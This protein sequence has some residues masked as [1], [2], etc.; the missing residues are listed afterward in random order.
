MSTYT[1]AQG[2]TYTY[3][4]STAY[5]SSS[6]S[7]STPNI[8]I[9]LAI[10]VASVPY[11]VTSIGA[12]AFQDN[13]TLQS[14]V[15]AT[16]NSV[17]E[18][19]SDFAFYSCPNLANFT[20]STTS[21]LNI[22]QQ[23]FFNCNKMTTASIT[24][25]GVITIAE[26]GGNGIF[27]YCT[28]LTNI[29]ITGTLYALP[30]RTFDTCTRLHSF[31]IPPSVTSLGNY[32]FNNTG[33]TNVTI[34]NT[35]TTIGDYIYANCSSLTSVTLP[36]TITSI[37]NGIFSGCYNLTS[38]TYTNNVV[39][40]GSSALENT[41]F[42]SF[43]I[44]A[45]ITSIGSGALQNSSKLDNI[46]FANIT[47]ITFI[48]DNA[49]AG[50][51]L[52]DDT[53]QTILNSIPSVV[54]NSASLFNGCVLLNHIVIPSSITNIPSGFFS[55]CTNLYDIT[56]ANI[57]TITS[58]GNYAFSG[59]AV[60]DDFVYTVLSQIT[61]VPEGLFQNCIFINNITIPTNITGIFGFSLSG[62]TNL[63][64]VTFESVS[65]VG[66]IYE[67]AFL[68][69]T[70][71][72]DITIPNSV[73]FINF[74]VF[75]NCSDL[76]HITLPTNANFTLLSFNLFNNC[77][78]LTSV[79]L[80]TSVTSIGNTTFDG[81][82]ALQQIDISN[83]TDLG[84]FIF[85]NCS[86]LTNVVLNN[87]LTSISQYMFYNCTGLTNFTIPTS[88]TKLGDG[89]F[90]GSGVSNTFVNSLLSR[91][92]PLDLT[93]SSI[94]Q[95]CTNITNLS[96]PSGVTFGEY[97]L[98]SCSN[99]TNVSFTGT[100]T[101]AIS[102]YMIRECVKLTSVQF[103]S[104][105]L[106]SIG[107]QSFYNCTLLSNISLGSSL[108]SI[109]SEAF[110][111]CT[112]LTSITIPDSV[113]SIAGNVFITCS[114]LTSINIPSSI[115]SIP[116]YFVYQCY[117]LT[118]IINFANITGTIGTAAF[119]ATQLS[120]SFAQNV[121]NTFTTSQLGNAIF[122][123]CT[124][125]TSVTI[126]A[127]YTVMS[128]YFSGCSNLTSITFS[129]IGNITSIQNRAFYGTGVNGA[130][131]NSIL[132]QFNSSQLGNTLFSNCLNV[133]SVIIPSSITSLP[134]S[135]FD[136]CANLT[137][138]TFSNISTITTISN[139][140]F[141]GTNV[142]STFA[143]NLL[144]TPTITF[145][146]SPFQNCL[147]TE[148]SIPAALT[149]N[150]DYLFYNCPILTSVT[151]ESGVTAITNNMFRDCHQLSSVTFAAPSSSFVSIGTAAFFLCNLS[152]ITIPSSVTTIGS[153]AFVGNPLPNE[154]V[155]TILNSFTQLV[156]QYTFNDN[157]VLSSVAIPTTYTYL[158]RIFE[159]CA[160]LSSVSL[161]NINTIRDWAF[162]ECSGLKN[163]DLLVPSLNNIN[164]A[165]FWLSGLTSITIP[166]T[167]SSIQ[168]QAFTNCLDLDTAYF[169]G[170]FNKNFFNGSQF[171]NESQ[172][173]A[174]Q[175]I[176]YYD[177]TA[178]YWTHIITY[179]LQTQS[180]SFGAK[181][182]TGTIVPSMP[183]FIG[184]FPLG[185][186][187]TPT[188]T[189]SSPVTTNPRPTFT[190][191]S[192]PGS[193]V[194][195]YDNGV[196]IPGASGLADV[197][198]DYSITLPTDLSLGTHSITARATL[199]ADESDFSA[200]FLI[201]ITSGPTP[202]PISDICFP[203][204]TP[205]LT[206]CGYVNIDEIDPKIHTIRDKKIIAV[207]QT[208]T[209]DKFLVC[210]EKD[211]LG[212]H[213][214]TKTTY[215]SQNHEIFYKGK[216]V[217]AKELLKEL[218]NVRTVPYNKEILYNVLLEKHDK[219]LVNNL[220]C[221]TLHPENYIAK[222]YHILPRLT[223]KQTEKLINEIN[224]KVE[225]RSILSSTNG[226]K[227]FL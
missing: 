62:C 179:P 99:L 45:N 21:D 127:S 69:C 78:S 218:T 43:T 8:T 23:V 213:Y 176:A 100:S 57:T 199:G 204:K 110:R 142:S 206:N 6:S 3:S 173:P 75:Q 175:K 194:Q 145:G 125:V 141:S 223:E 33:F 16:P 60:N 196:A 159:R 138:V 129:N 50:T 165:A 190:G 66:Y 4:G 1:D 96:I 189:S 152:T 29:T 227:L 128:D 32:A 15:F 163:I 55:N 192:T 18:S 131:V 73:T 121:L 90:S 5:V 17:F 157:D 188:L 139:R 95:N 63:T 10:T 133:T 38:L 36:N 28:S 86:N 226:R 103:G 149:L 124:L 219:M 114:S 177:P 46:I 58:I 97:F 216:M 82:S 105:Q 111:L 203:A 24:S 12:S 59:T 61:T 49:F 217:R 122:D 185:V 146:G 84:T 156:G 22:G 13:S 11:S 9:P 147:F 54:Q 135:F 115:T 31:T 183:G 27:I 34:P 2:I 195:L 44:P 120:N 40:I 184:L 180:K 19:I 102:S 170:N 101:V 193:T 83:V 182:G 132:N 35:I 220:I 178:K 130:F 91:T 118:N 26:N 7:I 25:T 209:H 80:P 87:T 52:L 47:N 186:L 109:G 191:T 108:T 160:N 210:I 67:Y 174:S 222:L 79:S 70:S 41:G 158:E 76:S 71:L 161:N 37:P 224:A 116:D 187:P 171:T 64:S 119:A 208:I 154:I 153:E 106:V 172:Y 92:P 143:I 201:T 126:P 155:Q 98:N 200:P 72:T 134:D 112:S 123:S 162:N 20:I 77:T 117:N 212:K 85:Q 137:S 202:T 214:P 169:Y 167:I 56:F 164:Y 88:V 14:I 113:T 215:I 48:G 104:A 144:T 68:S 211:A 51:Y 30:S 39:S 198:G 181:A 166:N 148:I 65:T 205:I 197:N 89:C 136:G 81:C 150:I 94:F 93:S 140:A 107:L 151:I 207:T 53:V 168:S 225:K 74:S 221:E 42:T